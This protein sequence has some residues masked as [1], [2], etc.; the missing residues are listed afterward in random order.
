MK[1]TKEIKVLFLVNLIKALLNMGCNYC[2]KDKLNFFL[3][4]SIDTVAF[5]ILLIQFKFVCFRM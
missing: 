4:C 1:H 5:V 3:V 2:R